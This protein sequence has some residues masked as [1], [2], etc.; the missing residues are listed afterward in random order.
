L[1]NRDL[2]ESHL[3]AVWLAESGQNLEDDIPHVLDLSE[4]GQPVQRV[5]RTNLSAGDLITRSAITMRRILDSVSN[6]LT[7]EN[8]P[9]AVEPQEFVTSVAAGAFTKFSAAFIR[10][11]QLYQ[12]AHAQLTEANRRSEMHGLS[13]D[14]RR[15][16][17]I[18][19]A[20]ATEQLSLLERGRST[21]GSD[22]YTY[23]YLATEGFLP[24]YNF[25]RLPIY[26]FVPAV[27][28]GGP[29]ASYLQ[30]A[31]FLAIAEFGPGSL[32]YHEGRG[33]RVTKAKISPELRTADGR[34]A[35]RALFICDQCGAAHETEPELCHVCR[36]PMA[37][38]HPIRNIVRID[39][40][41]TQPAERI[42]ANDEDRQRQGFE[43]QTVFA[44]PWR[45]GHPDVTSAIAHDDQ[46]PVLLIDYAS[47]ATISRVNKGLR[48]RR[49]R[50]VFGFGI[51]P[52]SGRWGRINE[53]EDEQAPPDAPIT[54]RIVPIV[55]DNK[56]AALLRVMG[57]FESSSVV[58]TLQH[59]LTRGLENVFQLE[60]GELLTEP[61]P[62]RDAR[63]AILAF[64]ATEGGAGVLSRLVAEPSR[65]AE[66]ARTALTLMHY[67]RVEQAIES[68]DA[69]MLASVLKWRFV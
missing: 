62:N 1:A 50:T 31:R 49:E 3:H 67:H 16:A 53:D 11:R 19:Q 24:G 14:E 61:V 12:S 44:W 2:I 22:F 60:E 68:G 10:W 7:A 4:G 35:T 30:R 21:G 23:R 54:Q 9:W 64:E 17:R 37:G 65:L 59:A 47:G 13:S 25:P 6:E 39:N 56:N 66:V 15:E 48:R 20:Q 58:A 42:T 33:F 28:A 8:A 34:L 18:S 36:S 29:K 69:E 45:D 51:D 41:E 32:I 52:S 40:V 27:G 38:I 46:G 26:A 43:I 5:I 57:N 55:E 63:R